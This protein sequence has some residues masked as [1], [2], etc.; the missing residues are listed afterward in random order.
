MAI[1]RYECST[2][3]EYNLRVSESGSG[4]STE[5]YEY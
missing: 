3:D 2:E 5:E 1:F 4:D